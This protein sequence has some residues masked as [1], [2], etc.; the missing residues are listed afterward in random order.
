M[1]DTRKTFWLACGQQFDSEEAAIKCALDTMERAD[2]SPGDY[3][4]CKC[5]PIKRVHRPAIA[6]EDIVPSEPKKERKKRTRKPK[7][8]APSAG[9]Q[10]SDP[11]MPDFLRRTKETA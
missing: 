3:V 1:T 7:A 4:V 11:N 5:I 6:I 10:A 9:V 2:P 8:D